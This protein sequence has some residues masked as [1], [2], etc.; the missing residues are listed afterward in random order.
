MKMNIVYKDIIENLF[1]IKLKKNMLNLDEMKK[2]KTITIEVFLSKLKDKFKDLE[3]TR[4][5]LADIIKDNNVSLKLTHIRHVPNK[6]FGKDKNLIT[7]SYNLSNTIPFLDCSSNSFIISS[8]LFFVIIQ[9]IKFLMFSNS[10]VLIFILFI[11]F[12]LYKL[13]NLYYTIKYIHT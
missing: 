7:K 12:I 4:K 2:N 13:I 6:S 10:V 1:H 8:T 9:L 5:H 3:L 11:L